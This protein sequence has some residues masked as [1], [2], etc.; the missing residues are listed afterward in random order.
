MDMEEDPHTPLILGREALKTMGAVINCKD[1]TITCEVADEKYRF[2]FLKTLKQPMLEK[3]WW[4]DL[5]ESELDE[6]ER[7]HGL[8]KDKCDE[9]LP[10][11]EVGEEEPL[12]ALEVESL[13][14]ET[15][16]ETQGAVDELPSIQSESKEESSTPPPKVK[17][18]PLP[19]SLKYACLD[20]DSLTSTHSVE[21]VENIAWF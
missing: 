9:D 6:M 15:H 19:P 17:L 7:F 5:V 2:E 13:E 11:E 12:C 20:D 16:P 21:E 10:C 14:S 4:V 8:Y 1:N 18:K 3:I